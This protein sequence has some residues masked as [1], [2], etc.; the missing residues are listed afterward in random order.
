MVFTTFVLFL[1]PVI[2]R[3][4]WDNYSITRKKNSL[5]GPEHSVRWAATGFLILA[6]CIINHRYIRFDPPFWAT[7]LFG[8]TI[9]ALFFD[10]G[11]NLAR[12]LHWSYVS[13]VKPN[14]SIWERIRQKLNAPAELIIKLW[15]CGA[16][17]G[18]YTQY[19]LL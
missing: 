16:G 7:L 6:L 5:D 2:I 18:C 15:L 13:P 12:G 10:Y 17:Y 8:T 14:P 11:L 4:L 9:F 3:I 19:Y 1:L